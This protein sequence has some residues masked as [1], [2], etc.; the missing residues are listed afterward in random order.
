MNWCQPHWDQ[1]RQ[2][3]YDRG[4]AHMVPQG[5]E[6]AAK[7][8]TEEIKGKDDSTGFDPLMRAWGM[9]NGRYMEIMGFTLECPPCLLVQHETACTNKECSAKVDEWIDGCTNSILQ[10]AKSLGLVKVS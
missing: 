7:Q 3:I 5:G 10:Y 4:M 6:N 8:M 9:I 2:A 1:L